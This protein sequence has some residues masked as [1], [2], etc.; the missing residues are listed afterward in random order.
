M[1]S[2]I[3]CRCL[4]CV[5]AVAAGC[6]SQ[7]TVGRAADD[8]TPAA[9]AE[10]VRDLD[11]AVFAIR[12]RAE[13]RLIELGEQAL[14]AL[15]ETARGDSAEARIRA[16]RIIASVQRRLLDAGFEHLAM[17]PEDKFDVE[18]G[19][20]LI[21]RLLNPQCRRETLT[22]QLDELA[23]RVRKQ[24]GGQIE[25]QAADPQAV[26]AA[27]RQVLFTEEGF[28]GNVADYQSPGNS[29]LE[30][31]LETKKGLPILLS[32]VVVSVA[33][34]LDVPIVGLSLPFRFM[35]KYDG[36]RAPPGFPREDIYF[37]PFDEGKVLT[38]AE[39]T[40]AVGGKVDP[41]IHLR[42]AEPRATMQRIFSNLI[43]HLIAAERGEEAAKAD[44]YRR[45]LE[46]APKAMPPQ[47]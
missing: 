21:S 11:D 12:E 40:E 18:Q 27:M 37:N 7:A 3:A 29:S 4:W 23:A 26:V 10:L 45:L 2:H 43:S 13:Q 17:Q 31:V 47:P 32:Q 8:P 34:R 16:R 15:A 22:L 42:P 14:P 46:P 6:C 25:P 20:W 1:P 24:L 30:V 5:V 38:L 33:R 19:M 39:V 44:H 36:S 41:A 35:V 28:A 9:L